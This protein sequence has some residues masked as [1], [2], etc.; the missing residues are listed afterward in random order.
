MS[1]R[2]SRPVLIIRILRAEEKMGDVVHSV[3][4]I[5]PA[6]LA[7]K[8]VKRSFPVLAAVAPVPDGILMLDAEHQ[9]F[10]PPLA[11]YGAPI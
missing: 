4:K 9:A 11:A 10:H 2:N 7:K 1:S 5:P 8:R 6:L 3:R